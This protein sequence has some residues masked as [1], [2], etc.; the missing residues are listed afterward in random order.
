MSKISQIEINGTNY[1]IKDNDAMPKIEVSTSDNGKFLRV[2][3][4]VWAASSVPNAE[5]ATF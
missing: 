2:V 4:G 3:D 1:E 5:E